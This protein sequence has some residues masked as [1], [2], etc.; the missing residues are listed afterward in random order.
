MEVN[1]LLIVFQRLLHNVTRSVK[2]NHCNQP[3]LNPRKITKR[4]ARR[5][6]SAQ[7]ALWSHPSQPRAPVAHGRPSLAAGSLLTARLPAVLRS[8]FASLSRRE[9]YLI[10]N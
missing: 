8:Q 2:L 6:L 10:Y 1:V 7:T 3:P 4:L 9:V 5:Q